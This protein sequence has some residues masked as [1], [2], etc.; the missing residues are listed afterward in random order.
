MVFGV[1]KEMK[2]HPESG[3]GLITGVSK[4]FN[5]PHA[6]MKIRITTQ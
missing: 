5:T 6:L 4:T 3:H 2:A 1:S